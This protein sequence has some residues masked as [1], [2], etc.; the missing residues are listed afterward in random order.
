MTPRF[1]ASAPAHESRWAG[2]PKGKYLNTILNRHRLVQPVARILQQLL[3]IF[4]LATAARG[5]VTAALPAASVARKSTLCRALS[6][7]SSQGAVWRPI[8]RLHNTER[9][10]YENP[11]T[12]ASSRLPTNMESP[13]GASAMLTIQTDDPD[14]PSLTVEVD[15]TVRD[16]SEPILGPLEDFG[17]PLSGRPSKPRPAPLVELN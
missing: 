10:R 5:H 16:P 9:A 7:A 4:A 3:D 8:L 2:S 15:A 6:P 14:T 12:S 13:G 11:L 1:A 17:P